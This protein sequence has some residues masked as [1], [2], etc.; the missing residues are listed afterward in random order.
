MNPNV[1]T[2]MWLITLIVVDMNDD[3]TQVDVL[4]V[5]VLNDDNR[6][7]EMCSILT[8]QHRGLVLL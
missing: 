3:P 6:L 7:S 4:Y 5:K 8:V 2:F 1:V